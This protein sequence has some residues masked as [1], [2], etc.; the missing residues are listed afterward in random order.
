MPTITITITA[1]GNTIGRTKTIS[2]PD[3]TNRFLPAHRAGFPLMPNET[4]LTDDQVIQRWADNVLQQLKQRVH[5][6]EASTIVI[7]P[8]DL[9]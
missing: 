7:P 8:V 6:Y 1:G 4:P 9:T 3:L 5:D 2:G